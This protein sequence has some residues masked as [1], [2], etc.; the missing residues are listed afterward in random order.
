MGDDETLQGGRN[1]C[2]NARAALPGAD[3]YCG[4][5]GGCARQAAGMVCFA[6][7][8]VVSSDGKEGKAKTGSF[9]LPRE[10][11]S[12]IDGGMELGYANDKVF[13][14]V[15]SKHGGGAVGLL[16]RG[17]IDRTEYYEQAL[18]L[19]LIPH[20]MPKLYPDGSTTTNQ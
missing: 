10:V 9:E 19:A 15:E 6:W 18:I 2:K 14:T 16:T 20:V 11:V 3:F 5:E 17:V 12:L 8:V 1:R 7:M 4:L 13:S